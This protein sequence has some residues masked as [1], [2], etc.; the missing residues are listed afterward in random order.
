MALVIAMVAAIPALATA[1]KPG[2][3]TAGRTTS[4]AD[5]ETGKT[6]DGGTDIA[7]GDSMCA[8][9]LDKKV[10]VEYDGDK[11]YLTIGL[12]M[13]SYIKKDSVTVQVQ[14]K[15]GKYKDVH[16]EYT[17]KS[18]LDGDDCYHYRF[19]VPDATARFSPRFYVMPM[20]RYVQFFGQVN[21]T[22]VAGNTTSF[23][24]EKGTAAGIAQAAKHKKARTA[25]TIVI[26]VVA[27]AVIATVCILLRFPSPDRKAHV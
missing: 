5:P 8:N 21:T 27:A 14:Q 3:Y 7:L 26:C 2:I 15:N 16:A 11:T 19:E 6:V 9:I 13:M 17:G 24:A 20:S 18:I 4:Y 23:K 12:G 10:L 1:L 25:W 22:P